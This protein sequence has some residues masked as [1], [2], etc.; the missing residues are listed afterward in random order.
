M[1]AIE[2][3]QDA[4]ARLELEQR[5][6]SAGV[7]NAEFGIPSGVQGSIIGDEPLGLTSITCREKGDRCRDS[8]E[9]SQGHWTPLRGAQF[10]AVSHFERLGGADRIGRAEAEVVEERGR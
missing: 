1:R 7:R 4:D 8:E 9:A 6:V 3:A 2:F 10:A 5:P